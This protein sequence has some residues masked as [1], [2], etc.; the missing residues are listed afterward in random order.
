MLD[1]KR[2]PKLNDQAH[3]RPI[4]STANWH[5]LADWVWVLAPVAIFALAYLLR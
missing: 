1:V 4:L 3:A 5:G 2:Y